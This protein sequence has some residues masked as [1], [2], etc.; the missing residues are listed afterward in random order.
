MVDAFTLWGLVIAL[1]I[2]LYLNFRNR[3]KPAESKGNVSA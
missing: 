2:S 1:I 3:V